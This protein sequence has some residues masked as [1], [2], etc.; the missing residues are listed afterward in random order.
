MNQ[1]TED[2]YKKKL[3]KMLQD[4]GLTEDEV[5]TYK[6]TMLIQKCL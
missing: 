3:D 1:E 4:D 5:E 2:N 6:K